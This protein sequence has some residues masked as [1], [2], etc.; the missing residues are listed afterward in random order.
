MLTGHKGL[1]HGV[2]KQGIPGA[3]FDHIFNQSTVFNISR[4]SH[5]IL[6]VGASSNSDME[7]FEERYEQVIQYFKKEN[8]DCHIYLYFMPKD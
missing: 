3:K 4:F 6:Y 8:S 7:Y 5:V 1:K 2:F